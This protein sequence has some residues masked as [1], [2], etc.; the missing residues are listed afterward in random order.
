MCRAGSYLSLADAIA[1]LWEAEEPANCAMMTWLR[2]RLW[3]R[4]LHYLSIDIED[5]PLSLRFRVVDRTDD[6]L[7]R[8]RRRLL[9]FLPGGCLADD[10][11]WA[12]KTESESHLDSVCRGLG[13]QMWLGVPGASATMHYDLQHNFFL[14]AHGQKRF[15]LLPPSAHLSVRLHPRWHGSRRQAQLHLPHIAASINE[16]AFVITLGAGDALYVPPMWFHHVESLE[17]N[18]AMN[19]WT[20]SLHSDSWQFLTRSSHDAAPAWLGPAPPPSKHWVALFPDP[21]ADEPLAPF[22]DRARWVVHAL[23]SFLPPETHQP[24]TSAGDTAVTVAA[25]ARGLLLSRYATLTAKQTSANAE[26]DAD[27]WD[28]A[29]WD[30]RIESFRAP[31]VAA[32]RAT[33]AQSC[34]EAPHNYENKD[35]RRDSE[36][37]DHTAMSIVQS[38]ATTLRALDA[39]S[40]TLLLEEWVAEFAGWV[41][42]PAALARGF[43]CGDACAGTFVAECLL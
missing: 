11:R 34:F 5:L 30:A 10:R 3:R 26:E 40:R 39:N 20:N 7:R 32:A 25:L 36:K 15:T 33:I 4:H 18:V 31:H 13:G 1:Q 6:G 37:G 17:T 27:E 29:I 41:V 42:G 9:E 24:N 21:R 2:R 43:E 12:D 14:Q 8:Q 35:R 22:F 23:I 16:T 19:F 38:T 28:V